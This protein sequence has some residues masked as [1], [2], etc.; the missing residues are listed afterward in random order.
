MLFLFFFLHNQS[1]DNFITQQTF[2]T[3]IY[4]YD[5]GYIGNNIVFIP[6]YMNKRRAEYWVH[7]RNNLV[8]AVDVN[9]FLFSLL[10]DYGIIDTF[11]N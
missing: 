1:I 5:I 10:K 9:F 11:V 3:Y 8:W 4:I 2:S 6:K 7:H